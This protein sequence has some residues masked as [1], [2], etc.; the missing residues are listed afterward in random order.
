MWNTFLHNFPKALFISLPVFALLLKL[1]YIRRRQ[2][3]YVDHGIFA[4]HLYV[5][6][7]LV[8][9]LVIGVSELNSFMKWGWLGWLTGILILYLFLYYYKAM[10]RFYGQGR[11]KTILKYF[12]LL[13]LS[14]FVQLIIFLCFLIFTVFEI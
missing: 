8:L 6:T 9:L 12:L 5:F 7:F 2:F 4:V 13:F 3:Y 11:A 14:F 10:H 1:L